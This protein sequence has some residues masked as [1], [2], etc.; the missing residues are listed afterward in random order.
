MYEAHFGLSGPPFQLNP[1]PS[2][3]FNSK[4]HGHAL[5][6]L[7]YGVMQGEGFI[8]VTGEIGAGK[9]TL[10]RTLLDELDRA[11]VVAAQI[12]STQLESGDL[13]QAII[14]AFGIPCNGSTK[15]SMI[16]TLEA[17]LMTLATQGR[18]ALLVI[19]EAQNLEIRAIE[20]LRML[21]NFQLGTQS[22]LQSFLVGQPELRK[23]LE[24]PMMEQLRQ[25]VTASCH[26]G[27]LSIDETRGYVEHRLKRVGWQQRPLITDDAFDQI[28]RWTGGVPRR[29]NRL[30]NRLLLAAF[31]EGRETIEGALV[32][33]TA[34]ELKNEIGEGSFEPAALPPR[35][36]VAATEAPAKPEPVVAP[37]A[38]A[39][40]APAVE[41]PPAPVAVAASP[42]VVPPV[43]PSD[44]AGESA[45][46]AT[47]NAVA[48]EPDVPLPVLDGIDATATGTADAPAPVSET[49][50]ASSPAVVSGL[51]LSASVASVGNVTPRMRETLPAQTPVLLGIADTTGGALRLAAVAKGL[52]GLQGAPRIVLFN[53][54][55]SREVWPWEGLDN[56]LPSFPVEW[57]FA[58]HFSSESPEAMACVVGQVLA[59]ALV[60]HA[61]V[62][63]L[64]AGDGDAVLWSTLMA[65]K[66]G[67]PV[68]RL[69]AGSRG[70]G[71]DEVLNAK[72]VEQGADV[73]FAPSTGAAM[74]VLFRAGIE[75][76]RVH[77]APAALSVDVLN[78]VLPLMT[79]P[80]GAFLRHRLPIFLGPRWSSEVE[81]TAYAVVAL[82]LDPARPQRAAAMLDVLV[83][84]PALP[85]L[86]WL[87]DAPTR[88]AIEQWQRTSDRADR[89][90]LVHDAMDRAALD[91][92]NSAQVLGAEIRSLPD[93]F[94]VLRGATGLLAEP[95]HVTADVA[96]LLGVSTLLLDPDRLTVSRQTEQGA[97]SRPWCSGALQ[98]ALAV[99][100]ADEAVQTTPSGVLLSPSG[101][102]SLVAQRLVAWIDGVPREE[103]PLAGDENPTRPVDLA[104][105]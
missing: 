52:Q 48:P 64:C 101:A 49:G 88:E 89:V 96:A 29:I 77:A 35:Q 91:Q 82:T 38:T 8:V 53:P 36:P 62:A 30:A 4:G 33:N 92:R 44:D 79:T 100:A 103:T 20:E 90:F 41:A 46:Q 25:R 43:P 78:A 56:Q 17:F 60:Q 22:L 13:L 105:A 50:A 57:Q 80:Y 9:T 95:G 83:D 39:T 94:S 2:F 26:L 23:K 98:E 37:P 73:L 93:A 42:Q 21:S 87:L 24:S 69:D 66:H 65:K 3:Y 51:D 7:R 32:E 18:R 54:G 99:W 74:Q 102:G 85:K 71:T 104:V 16:S 6:Y 63:V 28:F 75:A 68:V 84:L 61:P 31:L 47:P 12:V 72:L 59:Q 1:D 45:P 76:Q 97:Q 15:A 10:L 27:P 58:D 5:A 70:V 81:G 40:P 14:T 67:L 34:H 19:D 55:R 86:V 11:Q